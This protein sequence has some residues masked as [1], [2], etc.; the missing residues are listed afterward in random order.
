M[1]GLVNAIRLYRLGVENCLM[2]HL[3]PRRRAGRPVLSARVLRL[4]CLLALLAV[5]VPASSDTVAVKVKGINDTLTANARKVMSLTADHDKGWPAAKIRRLYRLAPEEIRKALQPYGYFN[6]SIDG[7]LKQPA[8]DDDQWQATFRVKH[9]PATKIS[10]LNLA[11]EGPGKEQSAIVHALHDT[12]LEAG[13]RLIQS[14]YKNTKNSL[15]SAA[16]QSG[17]LNAQFS[18]S[19]IRVDPKQ[20]TAAIDLVL[21][22]GTRY[23]FGD[24]AFHQSVLADQFAQRFVPFAAGE[25]FSDDKLLQLQLKL[26]K[27]DYYKAI[28]VSAKRDQPTLRHVGS[29]WLENMIFG[30]DPIWSAT[31]QLRVP[32][33]VRAK[34]SPPIHYRMSGGYGT[35]TGPRVGLGLDLRH[36]NRYGHQFH[37]DLQVSQVKQRLH[38]SYDIPIR[39]VNSDKLSF[40]GDIANEDFGDITSFRYGVGAVR[41]IG[42][43]FGR[44]RVSLH[45]L[46]ST[47]DLHDGAGDRTENLLYPEYNISFK[48]ANKSLN[49]TR[50]VSASVDVRGGSSA[51]LS[52]T[53]FMRGDVEAKAIYPLASKL[54]GLVRGHFGALGASDFAALPPSQRFFAGGQH[55][56]RGYGYQSISPTNGDRV[57]V[58]GKFVATAS[59]EADYWVY[60][61]FGA[62]AFFD[63]GDAA[64]N[65]NFDFKRGV[66]IGFRWASPVGMVAIDVTHPLDD[67]GSPVSLGISIGPRL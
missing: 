1:H 58:G 20:N 30:D 2:K 6:P 35:N 28:D 44:R 39:N 66:G 41:D 48:R 49:P 14:R 10:K 8:E 26:A 47:Y 19:A 18:Q 56:V 29:P 40:T 32:V 34:A 27:T 67:Q 42:W 46:R 11:V 15:A 55:S 63:M 31:N 59:V 45:F 12:D 64:N 57:D 61:S 9:G 3:R 37:A 17:Y 22:T 36:I 13:D 62:A 16:R 65:L 25:P 4:A 52:A 38:A 23:Y 50:G 33:N 51:V 24:V 21:N 53:N 7:N 54:D 60:G 5:A 43:R